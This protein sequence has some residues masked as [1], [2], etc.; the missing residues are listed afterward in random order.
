MAERAP[1]SKSAL[2]KRAGDYVS[3]QMSEAERERAERDLEVDA[4][5]REAVMQLAETM[6]ILGPEAGPKAPDAQRWQAVAAHIAELPQM[7]HGPGTERPPL[8][9]SAARPAGI[10]L[11]A[12]PSRRAL[13][14]MLGLVAAFALGYLAGRL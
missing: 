13:A 12:L 7:R 8:G 5:F 10:G 6:R 1:D 3:G 11:R 4:A 2:A 14:V 9:L